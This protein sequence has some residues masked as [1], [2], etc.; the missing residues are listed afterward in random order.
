MFVFGETVVCGWVWSCVA[1]SLRVGRFV[2]EKRW[3]CVGVFIGGR[4]EKASVLVEFRADEMLLLT[5]TITMY[6]S[7][8]V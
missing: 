1:S 5:V 7:G 3:G 2:S 4:R 6:S 8:M